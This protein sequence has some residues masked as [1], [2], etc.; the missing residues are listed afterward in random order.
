MP[1]RCLVRFAIVAWSLDLKYSNS[2]VYISIIL[3]A[4][5]RKHGVLT[6]YTNTHRDVY[7]YTSPSFVALT[8]CYIFHAGLT[9]V[10]IPLTTTKIERRWV[11]VKQ[12]K[13]H[14]SYPYR[15]DVVL[16]YRACSSL[17]FVGAT[18]Q[19]VRGQTKQPWACP[20]RH[21][22]YTRR[23]LFGRVNSSSCQRKW[24]KRLTEP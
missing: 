15:R 14:H 5:S 2:S 1:L 12:P 20:T 8:R 10:H 4:N 17:C 19:Q 13:N 16:V 24:T 6:M 23:P 22:L 18:L 9:R 11:I 7:E 21:L 3:L